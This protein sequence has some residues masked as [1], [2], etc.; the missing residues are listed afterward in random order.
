MSGWIKSPNPS[1]VDIVFYTLVYVLILLLF[2]P[3][4]LLWMTWILATEGPGLCW[5]ALVSVWDDCLYG[6]D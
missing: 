4:T 1:R 6:R 3:M 5:G 2:F